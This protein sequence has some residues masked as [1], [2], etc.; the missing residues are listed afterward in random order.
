MIGLRK[1][2]AAGV[3]CGVVLVAGAQGVSAAGGSAGGLV[4]L[5]TAGADELA[6]LPGIGPAKAQAIL[7]HRAQHPFSRADEL[8][9]VKGIGAKLYEKVKDQVTV[10]ELQAAPPKG[11]GS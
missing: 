10:G 7:Q 8:R 11:R 4:N 6:R 5:N 9:Q 2:I 3:L 1:A